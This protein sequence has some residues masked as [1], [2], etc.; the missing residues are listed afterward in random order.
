MSM[1]EFNRLSRLLKL[2]VKQHTSIKEF[3]KTNYVPVKQYNVCRR[4]YE[5]SVAHKRVLGLLLSQER[6]RLRLIG[7]KP[8]KKVRKKE[9]R[10][11]LYETFNEPRT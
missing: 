11:R 9:N 10:G 2:N 6:E 8:S 5:R 7:F 4:L 1:N 3:V